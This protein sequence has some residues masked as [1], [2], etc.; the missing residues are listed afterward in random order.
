MI[1]QDAEIVALNHPD[2]QER[3][4]AIDNIDDFHSLE[5][6]FI[7]DDYITVQM[8][9]YDKLSEIY[10][11][12]EKFKKMVKLW[13][14]ITGFKGWIH[15]IVSEVGLGNNIEK[16]IMWILKQRGYPDRDFWNRLY[17]SKS[18]N[19][20]IQRIVDIAL[21]PIKSDVSWNSKDGIEVR[22][23]KYGVQYHYEMVVKILVENEDKSLDYEYIYVRCWNAN[24]DTHL[25]FYEKLNYTKEE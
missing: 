13:E 11:H 4:K 24:P 25:Q 15:F 23:N 6:I 2:Y 20:I 7:T 12:T 1:S 9:A 10:G 14:S 17:I 21:M 16:T 3:M 8:K 19:R 18:R 22:Y 5:E